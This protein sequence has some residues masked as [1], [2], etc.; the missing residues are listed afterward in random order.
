MKASEIRDIPKGSRRPWPPALN[1]FGYFALATVAASIS[2]MV[3]AVLGQPPTGLIAHP[4]RID[5]VARPYAEGEE[6]VSKFRIANPLKRSIRV[7]AVHPGCSCTIVSGDG[8]TMVGVTIAPGCTSELR[9]ATT[10]RPGK[11]A[12]QE[13]ATTV[14]AS[15]EGRP[16]AP[17]RLVVSMKVKDSLKAYPQGIQ[18]V[19]VPAGRPLSQ[20][21]VLFTR[22]G[23]VDPVELTLVSSDDHLI[24]GTLSAATSS[25]MDQFPGGF[26]TH[27]KIE[28]TVA[29][30]EPGRSIAASLSLMDGLR[31]VLRLPVNCTAAQ[32]YQLS[33][34]RIELDGRAGEVVSRSL[35]YE[36]NDRAWRGLRAG[37][38]PDGLKISVEPFD[39]RTEVIRVEARIPERAPAPPLFVSFS[40][41]D[42]K[43]QVPIPVV[44]R[45]EGGSQ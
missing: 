34:D 9:L 12:V 40:A 31:E 8:A 19:E 41:G 15:C 13:F 29:A 42:G 7:D 32:P 27:Y 4:E 38:C 21:I 44:I 33:E 18:V 14:V 36:A 6:V 25:E 20:T 26:V 30:I 5:H 10:I 28:A 23:K 22:N 11:D 2:L 37:Q 17:L 39:G 1:V 24:H 45:V 3:R 43:Q 35:Y 16:L